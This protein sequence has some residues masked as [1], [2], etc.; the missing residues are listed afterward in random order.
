M[1]VVRVQK[2]GKR[3][4]DEAAHLSEP[5]IPPERGVTH[6][7]QNRSLRLDTRNAPNPRGLRRRDSNLQQRPQPLG[8][9]PERVYVGR[10]QA[11]TCASQSGNKWR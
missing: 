1:A 2:T 9:D 5:K 7:N 4:H 3:R 10:S 8:L 11:A 6:L